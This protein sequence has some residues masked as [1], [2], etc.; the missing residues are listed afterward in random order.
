MLH[1]IVKEDTTNSVKSVVPWAAYNDARERDELAYARHAKFFDSA[2]H[3]QRMDAVETI[4]RE[5]FKRDPNYVT[6]RGMG[7]QRPFETVKYN[8][9][10][11]YLNS[12]STKD[13]NELLYA[14]LIALGDVEPVSRNGHFT[15]KVF[16]KQAV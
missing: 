3:N 9:V 8:Q 6:C 2:Q 7:R 1:T 11:W 15:V 5:F 10:G 4:L 12:R 13:K 16:A 14:P